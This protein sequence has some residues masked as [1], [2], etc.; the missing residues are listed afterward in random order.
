LRQ[1]PLAV[2]SRG[3]ETSVPPLNWTRTAAPLRPREELL[4]P[5][6]ARRVL[7][8]LVSLPEVVE[9]R[10]Q[11]CR[12]GGR[13]GGIELREGYVGPPR[14]QLNGQANLTGRLVSSAYSTALRARLE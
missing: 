8:P 9:D 1:T 13:R 4:S 7:L 10:G 6:L 14:W 11:S 5:E 12:K 2:V 3:N